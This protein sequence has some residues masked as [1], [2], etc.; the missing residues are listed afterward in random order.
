MGK[1]P[2]Q[3]WARRNPKNAAIMIGFTAL[4]ALVF[5]LMAGAL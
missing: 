3:G 5:F 4:M 1:S 2:F